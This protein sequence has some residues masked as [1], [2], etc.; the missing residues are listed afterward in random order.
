[1]VMVMVMVM[2]MM[3]MMLIMMMMMWR[4]EKQRPSVAFGLGHREIPAALQDLWYFTDGLCKLLW[5]GCVQLVA[6]VA[7]AL[8]AVQ[9]RRKCEQI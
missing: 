4:D 3:M 1:M 5:S 8:L 2:M 9:L 6:G 7:S